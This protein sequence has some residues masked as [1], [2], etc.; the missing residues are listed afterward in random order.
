MGTLSRYA[1]PVPVSASIMSSP[2]KPLILIV[3][4]DRTLQMMLKVAMEQEGF[5]V[6]Q[7][8]SGEQCIQDYQRLHPDMV[9]ID[10]MMPGID[11]FECCHQIRQLPEANQVP[12]LIIT[13]LDKPEFVERAFQAGASDYV[14]K[15]I[16]W[17]VLSHRVRS[18]LERCQNARQAEIIKDSLIRY[19]AWK[20]TQRQLWI[21]PS[22]T[23]PSKTPSSSQAPA[24]QILSTLQSLNQFVAASRTLLFQISSQQWLEATS[25]TTAPLTSKLSEIPTDWLGV[26]QAQ[27]PEPFIENSQ[28]HEALQ[29][30]FQPLQESLEASSLWPYPVCTQG[31]LTAVLFLC[32]SNP[33]PNFLTLEIESIQDAANYIAYALPN[34]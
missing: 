19:Q 22:K 28:L 7:A 25:Q 30:T 4:D 2:K 8:G 15:P 13:V 29:E 6:V 23:P 32:F 10:A 9:L 20:E 31:K 21:L 12:I 11:G 14:T 5:A 18:L 1:T 17:A 33:K 3:D 24:A 16:S 27:F 34:K 26:L